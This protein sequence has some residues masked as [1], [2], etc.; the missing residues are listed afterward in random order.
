M[1]KDLI[2][3]Q[4]KIRTNKE[5]NTKP[6]KLIIDNSDNHTFIINGHHRLIE[7]YNKALLNY[8]IIEMYCLFIPTNKKNYGEGYIITPMFKKKTYGTLS[9]LKKKIIHTHIP[10]I[11]TIDKSG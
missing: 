6:I 1:Y 8:E 9:S 7:D 11:R 5:I 10:P 4:A 3:T 2:T